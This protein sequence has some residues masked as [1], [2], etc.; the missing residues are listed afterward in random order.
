MT[1][2]QPS[3]KDRPTESE[4]MDRLAKLLRYLNQILRERYK[5]GDEYPNASLACN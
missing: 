4:E 5:K 3:Y 2:D 1:K